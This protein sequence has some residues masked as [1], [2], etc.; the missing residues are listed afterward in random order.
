M[1]KHLFRGLLI[2]F[3]LFLVPIGIIAAPKV[4]ETWTATN[5]YLAKQKQEKAMRDYQ[6]KLRYVRSLPPGEWPKVHP[7]VRDLPD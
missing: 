5:Q 2:G 4:R 3:A 7:N 6:K 1:N